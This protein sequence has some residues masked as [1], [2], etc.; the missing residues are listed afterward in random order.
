MKA[1]FFFL[2]ALAMLAAACQRDPLPTRQLRLKAIVEA[3]TKAYYESDGSFYWHHGDA[4][5]FWS[6]WG[7]FPAGSYEGDSGTTDGYFSIDPLSMK[8]ARTHCFYPHYHGQSYDEDSKQLTVCIPDNYVLEKNDLM[9]MPLV[10]W[11]TTRENGDFHTSLKHVG[12]AVLVTIWNLPEG[13]KCIVLTSDKRIS[14]EFPVD[15]TRLGTDGC[16]AVAD[17]HVEDGQNYIQIIYCPYGFCQKTTLCFPVPTGEYRLGLEVW[18]DGEPYW[19]RPVGTHVNRI[20][21]G[22]ILQLPAVNVYH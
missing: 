11:L 13:V 2:A 18:I 1:H 21:R 4:L 22:T 14:G 16:K 7:F 20:G 5:S 3:P 12:G 8:N 15:M 6:D 17:N 10:G 9:L 19:S